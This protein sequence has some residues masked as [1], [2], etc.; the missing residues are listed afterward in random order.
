MSIFK[1]ERQYSAREY[2][3]DIW[4]DYWNNYL[5]IARYAECNHITTAQANEVIGLAR[6]VYKSTH[7]EA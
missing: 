5:S 6:A 7:P 1:P 4:L 2:L 3:V